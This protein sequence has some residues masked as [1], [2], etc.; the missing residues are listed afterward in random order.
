MAT[1]VLFIWSIFTPWGVVYGA[2][3][4]FITMTGWFWPKSADEGGTQ[5][6]PVLRRTLPMPGE[7]P[8]AGGA[9]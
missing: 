5:P 6:W 3:P 4:L 8:G 7:M 9:L 1:T 2:I